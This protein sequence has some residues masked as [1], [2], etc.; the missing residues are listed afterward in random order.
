MG[1]SLEAHI[2][3]EVFRLHQFADV[4]KVRADAAKGRIRADG[5]RRGFG[6]IGYDKAVMVRA[7]CFDRHSAQQRVIKI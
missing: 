7:R 1:I 6:E 5:F 3:R 4:M 2:F